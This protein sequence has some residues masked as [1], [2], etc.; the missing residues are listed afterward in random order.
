MVRLP[1]N[2]QL[3]LQQNPAITIRTTS[4]RNKRDSHS[5]DTIDKFTIGS[6]KIDPLTTTA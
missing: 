2:Q 4:L 5:K 6:A 3:Q 1:P